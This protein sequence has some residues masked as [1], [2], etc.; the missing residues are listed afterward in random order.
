MR[1][2]LA[3]QAQRD[4]RKLRHSPDLERLQGAIDG[5]RSLGADADV[6][7]LEGARPWLRLRTGDWRII[8]RRYTQAEADERGEDG[9]LVA[10]VVNRR[11]LADAIRSL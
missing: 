2:D 5:L 11:D 10:R 6:K 4:L 8:Y 3:R 7:A 1:I 9:Y